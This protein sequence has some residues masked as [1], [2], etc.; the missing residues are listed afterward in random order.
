MK[1]DPGARVCRAHGSQ[2][3]ESTAAEAAEIAATVIAAAAL[4]ISW[5]LILLIASWCC[6]LAIA[7][8]SSSSTGFLQFSCSFLCVLLSYCDTRA[9][10]FRRACCRFRLYSRGNPA[11][12]S[13]NTNS[14]NAPAVVHVHGSVQTCISLLLA[15]LRRRDMGSPCSTLHSLCAASAPAHSCFVSL[16]HFAM[17]CT[18]SALYVVQCSY[19]AKIL[20]RNAQL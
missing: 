20:A 18:M 8:G 6:S 5:S 13:T 7:A 3:G 9:S 16:R 2:N 12:A 14:S 1:W 15:L 11:T 17:F 4:F 10:S 19:A